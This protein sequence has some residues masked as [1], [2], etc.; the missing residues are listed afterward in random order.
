MN[1]KTSLWLLQVEMIITVTLLAM[2]IMVPFFYSI[3]MDQG[4]IGLS[5]SLF[6]VV[7][8][9]TNIP[10]GWIADRFSRKFCN[11]VGDL[12]CAV[13]LLLYCQATGFGHVVAAEVVFGVALALSQGAD[14]GLLKAYTRLLDP[15]GRLFIRKNVLIGM[16]Q[17][18]AQ[19]IALIVGGF[20]GADNPRLAIGLSAISYA[21]GCVLSLLMKEEG[22][23]LVPD[24]R[25]P[26]RDMARV[27]RKV[28]AHDAR[29]RWQMVAYAVGREIT[30]AVV[31]ALTPLLLLAGVPLY[32]VAFGWV[33]NMGANVCGAWLAG[34]LSPRL[35]DWQ[36]F[37]L[38]IIGV[39]FAL[40]V[41][42]IHLSLVTVWLYAFLGIAQG[43]TSATL[44]PMVQNRA[45][46][47][48][49]S[50]VIS[51]TKSG[52]QLL[53][54]PLVWI[55]NAF[56]VIDIRLTMVATVVIFVPLAIV[57]AR[58]LAMLERM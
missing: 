25:N 8:L 24:H 55:I 34:R 38:P 1:T 14:G 37:L 42:S 7:L 12:G 33:V 29:L 30:H 51:I 31:W 9:L 28:V 16:W 54:I 36:R 53:Y 19:A 57:T 3:G 20:I 23:R 50:T 13:A 26:F 32:L 44:L 56:G 18:I 52:A 45:A 43:W 21:I 40:T 35:R 22:E 49:Q 4:Q 47:D 2:P 27:T 46:D 10:T 5:Q 11:A 6:T 48:V 39:V 41:M 15:S 58:R 17:P